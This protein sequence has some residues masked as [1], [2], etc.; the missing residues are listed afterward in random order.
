MSELPAPLTQPD[1]D[2]TDF[3]F[4]PLQI[5]RLR[6]SKAW[7]LAKRNPALAF[8]MVNLWTASWHEV[9][10]ASLEDDDDVLAEF[11]MCDPIKW[12]KLRGKV[13]HGWIKC[14]DGR[15]YHPIVAEK[16]VEAWDAKTDQ[17]WRTECA[18]IKKH[19]DR[20]KMSIPRPTFEEWMSQGCPQGQ[21]LPVPRDTSGTGAGQGGETPSKREGEGQREG[22]GQGELNTSVPN[23]TGA[24][25]PPEG[26]S[27][28]DAIFQV[29]VP[30]L[31]ERGMPDKSAR[32]LL[33]GARK[34]LGDDGAWALAQECMDEKPLEPASWLAAALNARIGR[35]RGND[36]FQVANA[37]HTSTEAAAAASVEQRGTVV[38]ETG[39]VPFD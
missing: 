25:A 31:V 36:K 15:L 30:W 37:D 8:Y 2:L 21:R 17:R 16:A 33:G 9:P 6:R 26:I 39:E 35:K 23:G 34:Q 32:S 19:N 10:A 5:M 4:M 24:A 3:P 28:S 20:H 22:Q 38:P 14:S 11:A 18:R 12:D 27:P 7:L 13:M 1:C 29:A